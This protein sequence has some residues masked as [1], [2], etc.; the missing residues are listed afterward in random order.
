MCSDPLVINAG[1]FWH[2][3]R[4]FFNRSSCDETYEI[5]MEC[6]SLL[7]YYQTVVNTKIGSISQFLN[8][9]ST[10]EIKSCL[11]SLYLE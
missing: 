4:L 10:F 2:Y 9:I 3:T 8:K 11:L 1:L 6:L 5:L 7:L